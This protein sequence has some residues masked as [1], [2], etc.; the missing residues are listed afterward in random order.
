MSVIFIPLRSHGYTLWSL[1]YLHVVIHVLTL[2][3]T[4]SLDFMF[5]GHVVFPLP[6]SYPFA[7][8]TSV[9]FYDYYDL[10]LSLKAIIILM[11]IY[12]GRN[13]SHELMIISY[14]C[15]YKIIIWFHLFPLSLFYHFLIS[16]QSY[17]YICL[18]D[19]LQNIYLHD[20][21]YNITCFVY[22]SSPTITSFVCNQLEGKHTFHY[23]SYQWF[24]L[25]IGS[26]LFP[27]WWDH[28]SS[29]L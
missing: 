4:T 17:L 29:Y 21:F 7:C 3:M 14:Y 20:I 16:R 6:F 10:F 1:S 26:Y 11:L 9:P 2:V 23:N 22:F 28:L 27:T 8:I 24:C 5:Y 18:H 19:C 13:I 12:I 15:S 25:I